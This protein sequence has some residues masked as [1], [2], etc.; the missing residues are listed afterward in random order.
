VIRIER[1]EE[2]VG[3]AEIRSKKL[4]DARAAAASDEKLDTSGYNLAREPLHAAQYRKCCWCEQAVLAT[5][6]DVEHYR[7]KSYYWWLSWTWENLLFACA[8]CNRSHKGK[9]FPLEDGSRRLVAE[10]APPGDERPLLIDPGNE[11][12]GL[13][14][15]FAKVGGHWIPVPRDGSQRGLITIELLG[16]DRMELLDLYDDHAA[17]LTHIVERTEPEERDAQIRALT[18]ASRPFSALARAVLAG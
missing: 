9:A 6:N 14:I 15:R 18:D 4:A 5:Y 8:R 11:D 17:Y 3:L 12:P 10:Q 16:L 2:P 13:Y 1:G 7:P